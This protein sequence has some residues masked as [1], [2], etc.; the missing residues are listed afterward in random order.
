M[1]LPKTTLISLAVLT[2]TGA[3]SPATE[4]EVRTIHAQPS[5]VLA[6]KAVEVAVTVRGGQMAPVTFFRDSAQPVRPYYVSPWQDEKPS[7]MPA[8]VLNC[9]RGDFFCVPFGGNT[10]EVAGEKHPPHGEIVGAA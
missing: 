7:E 4:V 2:V 10:D 5:F 9:L 1:F 3:F 8:P 6:T